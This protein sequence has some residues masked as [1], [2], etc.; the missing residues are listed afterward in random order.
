MWVLPL[1]FKIKTHRKEHCKPDYGNPANVV[2][3]PSHLRMVQGFKV[4][5]LPNYYTKL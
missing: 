5:Q 4:N 3:L 2:Q 1:S